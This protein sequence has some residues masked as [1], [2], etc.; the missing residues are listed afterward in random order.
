MKS[1]GPTLEVY[2]SCT[3]A[4]MFTMTATVKA[5][6]SQRWVFRNPGANV[7]GISFLPVVNGNRRIGDAAFSKEMEVTRQAV[8]VAPDY[9]TNYINLTNFALAFRSG[10][11]KRGRAFTRCRREKAMTTYPATLRMLWPFSVRIPGSKSYFHQSWWD[12]AGRR[13][14]GDCDAGVTQN[15]PTLPELTPLTL[16]G[17]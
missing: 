7:G 17:R 4:T 13:M 11:T 10:S 16:C 1:D 2:F 15:L 5:M 3:A 9:L 12:K 8:R 14:L 6:D